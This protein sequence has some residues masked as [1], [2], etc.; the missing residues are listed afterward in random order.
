MTG[1]EPIETPLKLSVGYLA[2]RPSSGFRLDGEVVTFDG[3]DGKPRSFIEGEQVGWIE[4][5]SPLAMRPF[6]MFDLQSLVDAADDRIVDFANQFGALHATIAPEYIA[7]WRQRLQRFDQ[8]MR[9]W[10]WEAM[11]GPTTTLPEEYRRSSGIHEHAMRPPFHGPMQFTPAA[12]FGTFAA[13]GLLNCAY[14]QAAVAVASRHSF[15]ICGVCGRRFERIPEGGRAVQV[16][17]SKA[18]V[19]KAYR[20]RKE[21][22]RELHTSG[23]TPAKI[24]KELGSSTDVVKGWLKKR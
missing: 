10:D 16:Y 13:V 6:L 5:R 7:V 18:C 9:E 22:A 11:E 1:F 2:W 8:V 19:A 4:P 24:A 12:G 23:M 20:Q 15:P 21:R 17:C 14:T 3:W